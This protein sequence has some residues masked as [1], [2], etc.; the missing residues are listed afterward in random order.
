MH[1]SGHM[2]ADRYTP[3]WSCDNHV[4][5][6]FVIIETGGIMITPRPS[7]NDATPKPGYP[8][9]PFFG[10][11]PVLLDDKV[12]NHGYDNCHTHCP[13]HPQGSLIE[14]NNVTG[15]LCIRSPWPAMAR[16]IY[17]D[18]EKYI[19]TYFTQYPG[20]C[21]CVAPLHVKYSFKQFSKHKNRNIPLYGSVS[22][23]CQPF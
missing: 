19:N 23:C 5:S 22:Y 14:G 2:V 3:T 18:H 6:V 17:G 1:C 21:V 4:T 8:M 9:R 15:N 13:T 11:D 16:T 20:M 12:G 10:V 7:P